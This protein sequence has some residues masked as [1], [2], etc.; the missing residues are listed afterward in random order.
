MAECDDIYNEIDNLYASV[1]DLHQESFSDTADPQHPH[2][3]PTLKPYQ[4]KAVR[5]MLSRES[6]KVTI[7]DILSSGPTEL[8][9]GGILADEMGL[10]KTVEVIACMLLNP[11]TSFDEEPASETENSFINSSDTCHSPTD[12]SAT[13]DEKCSLSKTHSQR[14]RKSKS[15]LIDSESNSADGITGEISD[16]KTAPNFA[17][18]SGEDKHDHLQQGIPESFVKKESY[19][20]KTE[21]P[22]EVHCM[23]NEPSSPSST[24]VITCKNEPSN[25]PIQDAPEE[26]CSLQN[27]K[28]CKNKSDFLPSIDAVVKKEVLNHKEFALNTKVVDSSANS[29]AFEESNLKILSQNGYDEEKVPKDQIETDEKMCIDMVNQEPQKKSRGWKRK[30]MDPSPTLCEKRANIE[31]DIVDSSLNN[32]NVSEVNRSRKGKKPVTPSVDVSAKKKSTSKQ[33]GSSIRAELNKWY[34]ELLAEVRPKSRK[35][36]EETTSNLHCFCDNIA[37]SNMIQCADCQ[38]YQHKACVGFNAKKMKKKDYLCP[39]CILKKKPIPAKTTFIV[40]PASIADQWVEEIEKHTNPPLKVLRYEGVRTSGYIQPS[41]I[42]EYDV[43]LTTYESLAKE[44]NYVS[45]DDENATRSL[46]HA[47]RY[48]SPQSPLICVQWWR[49]CLDEAQMVEMSNTKPSLMTKRLHAIHRWAVTG[50]PIQKTVDDLMG[51]MEF[52]GIEELAS[53]R[54]WRVLKEKRDE[55]LYFLSCLMWRHSKHEVL[56][57]FGV[58]PQTVKSVWLKFSAIESHFYQRQHEE[59][60]GQFLAKVSKYP[61]LNIPL[62]TIDRKEVSRILQP[63]LSLRQACSH[64]QAVRGK[65]LAGRT[66]MTMT[67]LLD[68]MVKKTENESE[69]FLRQYI[70]T[71]NGMA[72][73]NII[74]D[75]L[76][77]AVELYREVLQLCQNYEGSLTVDTLQKIHT[78]HNLAEVLEFK[79]ENIAPTLRDATAKED[80]AKLEKEYLDKRRVVMKNTQQQVATLA[81]DIATLCGGSTLGF[82]EW[83]VEVI[84]WAPSSKELITH[85]KSAL[86]EISESFIS[87]APKISSKDR[88]KANLA[89]WLAELDSLRISIIDALHSLE[90]TATE[91]LVHKA[92]CCHLRKARRS[93][94]SCPLCEIEENLLAYESLL[95][96]VSSKGNKS[97]ALAEV[98]DEDDDDDKETSEEA[99]PSTSK[100]SNALQALKQVKV[101]EVSWKGSWKNSQYLIVLTELS[102]FARTKSAPA[103]WQNSAKQHLKLMN[104]LKREFKTLRLLWTQ[105][106]ELVQSCDELVMA[107]MRLRLRL[108]SDTPQK[109]VS[110]KLDHIHIIDPNQIQFELHRLKNE[111]KAAA[112]NLKKKTGTLLYLR[113]LQKEKSE[114]KV[115]ICPICRSEMK[116]RWVVLVCGHCI[117][118][119][120][121]PTMLSMSTSKEYVE[122]AI[123]REKGPVA[124]I[125]YVDCQQRE[126]DDKVIGSFSTKITGV[127]HLVKT[128]TSED[129]SVKILVFSSWEKVLDILQEG[130]E[131]NSI[132]SQRL[133]SGPKHKNSIKNF[134]TM[135]D[136]NVLLLQY[137]SGSKG[138]N[139][140][141]ATHII[142]VEPVLNPSDELQAVGRVHRMGQTKPTFVHRFVIENTIEEKMLTAVRESEINQWRKNQV[143]LQQLSELFCYNFANSK[144][145]S[146][147]GS[148]V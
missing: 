121:I 42:A 12:L 56:D 59:C 63:L 103:Q 110:N 147:D 101:F 78:L 43:L 97:N 11:R 86:A 17:N 7:D 35:S 111:S 124:E 13:V 60:S 119:E 69:E 49:V 98:E 40:S 89:I 29:R 128:L 79:P 14:K 58:P 5:W 19:N 134:K 31:A 140:I 8:P 46:R 146:T 95:F 48:F 123:C 143:T 144:L 91:D 87:I 36:I 135:K 142:L 84:D 106:S 88:L 118:Y 62:Q 93:A 132:K 122:C 18:F 72:G 100:E 57:E 68:V 38:F 27:K 112:E 81:A 105:N 50:T 34:E 94:K 16:A 66:T 114:D 67:D 73:I 24:N 47:K 25:S 137:R 20:E 139:L 83:W 82:S 125:S 107:K 113:N 85:L 71:L 70:A 77:D 145:E 75:Q 136:M 129:S 99:Q 51:L 80:A 96:M 65:L 39:S 138:L 10:G 54:K 148:S 45:G 53:L 76:G 115:N 32:E 90:V 117:C 52:L 130:F 6:K 127:I 28:L 92:L 64:P 74:I 26:W 41:T 120:C 55:F 23:E 4:C 2:L 108:K 102:N 116:D 109:K 15:W 44:L 21:L 126:D 1:Q 9:T 22:K 33:R 131:K 141:E 61:S 30:S 104:S 133:K 37:E 3:V